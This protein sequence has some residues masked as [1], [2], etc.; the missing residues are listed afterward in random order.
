[1]KRGMNTKQIPQYSTRLPGLIYRDRPG[2]YALLTNT[3]NEIGPVLAGDE[4]HLPGGGVCSGEASL[5]AL[6]RELAE[7]VGL[8]L[9]QTGLLGRARQFCSARLAPS[10]LNKHCSYYR[11]IGGYPLE[12][13]RPEHMLSWL[14]TAG[15]ADRLAH[16][17]H[18]WAVL[19]LLGKS[20]S[21]Y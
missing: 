1:M 4:Y 12:N 13:C 6:A 14:P 8:G 10:Y 3:Q 21:D 2:V 7:E 18:A 11:L 17:S 9:D 5:S 19:E 16:Q 20:R 15:A